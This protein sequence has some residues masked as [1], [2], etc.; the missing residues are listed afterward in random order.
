[1]IAPPDPIDLLAAGPP[2]K[3]CQ[4]RNGH[5]DGRNGH[6]RVL[7]AMPEY[8]A[9]LKPHIFL[10]ENVPDLVRH[11]EGKTFPTVL[12]QLKPRVA[13]SFDPKVRNHARVSRQWLIAY[14]SRLRILFQEVLSQ[15]RRDE[16]GD[17]G[18]GAPIG[19]DPAPHMG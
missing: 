15:A 14:R 11:W 5:H 17:R 7:M 8:V 3:G 18:A 13:S 10:I 19:R 1:M 16:K 4:I 12:A 6:N 2:C 9:I